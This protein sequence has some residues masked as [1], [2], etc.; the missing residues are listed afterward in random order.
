MKKI[1][2]LSIA[3]MLNTCAVAAP[4]AFYALD[5][6][7]NYDTLLHSTQEKVDLTQKL[8]LVALGSKELNCCFVFGAQSKKK[9]VPELKANNEEPLL[10]SSRGDETYQFVGAYRPT[11]AEKPD[12]RLQRD[13]RRKTHR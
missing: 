8:P 5:I 4:P 7:S 12:N 11:V 1:Y 13:D 2:A 3:F 9:G 10:S 6:R